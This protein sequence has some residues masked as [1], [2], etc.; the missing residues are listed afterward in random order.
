M[1]PERLL[2]HQS[3]SGFTVVSEFYV[4]AKDLVA[5]IIAFQGASP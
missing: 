1:M 4:T 3:W 5:Y 2:E